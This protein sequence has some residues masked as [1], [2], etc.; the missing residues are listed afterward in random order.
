MELRYYQTAA[1]EAT[2]NYL[3]QNQDKNPCIVLPTGSGKT[4]ALS[5][6]CADVAESGGRVLVL[7][8]V[9][10]LLQ[11]A[12]EKLQAMLP[13]GMVG[14]N[15][16][17]LRSRDTTHPVIV[18]GIQSVYT[19]ACQMGPFNAIIVDEAH[20]IPERNDGMYR[21]FITA[22]K[23][24]NP[25][26][27]IIGLT[28]TPYRL[29]SG[30]ICG[31]N[32]ILHDVSYEAG[33][34]ELI[35]EGFLC[36]IKTRAGKA[37]AN[38]Q[39]IHTRGGEYIESE[40]AERMEEIVDAACR[41]IVELTKDRHSVLVFCA[42]VS[43]AK[44]VADKFAEI[45]GEYIGLISGKTAAKNRAEDLVKFKNAEIKFLVNVNVLTTGFDAPN[46]DAIALLRATLSPGL[47]SQ[48]LGRGLRVHPSKKDCVILDYGE[49]ALRHGPLDAIQI[50]DKKVSTGTGQAPAK[51]CPECSAIVFAG[52]TMC[53]ECGY[54]FPLDPVRHE[55]TA[56]NAEV[57]S[58]QETVE[59]M[60][61]ARTSYFVHYKKGNM[62]STPTMRVEY[63]SGGLC[64]QTRREW[65]CFSHT[66]WVRQKADQWWRDRSD[67]PLPEDVQDAV[68]LA[69]SGA[70]A[71]TKKI[72]WREVSGEKFGN[73]I[74]YEIDDKKPNMDDIDAGKP[75]DLS[76]ADSAEWGEKN[77]DWADSFGDIPF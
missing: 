7:A 34:R 55:S 17:G 16:A 47:Y 76:A 8:H 24:V 51:E 26:V 72:I 38:L 12:A 44:H 69:N 4:N 28:A 74:G 29:D 62:E 61:V 10:E 64:G 41:E 39:D 33:I 20:L 66:G 73:I 46:I 36:N 13:L 57:L 49:N 27:R 35:D 63:E 6:I 58:G 65:L 43:H 53:P 71:R 2:Y 18:A 50:V 68:A 11:Q 60:H 70:L 45:T 59:E 56:G 5:R 31:S 48:M 54:E 42:S 22:A 75:F 30:Y 21:S 15:S 14:I 77:T 32:N 40:V 52:K 19:K 37:R 9:K 25:R 23:M 1:I 3:N 67:V